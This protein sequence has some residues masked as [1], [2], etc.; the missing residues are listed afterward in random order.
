MLSDFTSREMVPQ[1]MILV[2]DDQITNHHIID[3][4]LMILGYKNRNTSVVYVQ[5]GFKAVN[6]V[7]QCFTDRQP[8]R[9]ALILS[10]LKMPHIDGYLTVRRI[11]EVYTSMGIQAEDQPKIVAVTSLIE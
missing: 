1:G 2:V 9:Y 6:H 3:S 5:D 10:E 8:L 4:F 7:T 11:R